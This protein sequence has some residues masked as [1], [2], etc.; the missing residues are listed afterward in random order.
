MTNGN[1]NLPNSEETEDVLK[2]EEETLYIVEKKRPKQSNILPEQ[3]ITDTDNHDI[4]MEIRKNFE[5][6]EKSV[7][8]K[9]V[10]APRAPSSSNSSASSY[11]SSS[12]LSLQQQQQE[13]A[14]TLS[15]ASSFDQKE[16]SQL[17]YEY[18]LLRVNLTQLIDDLRKSIINFNNYN[19][20]KSDGTVSLTEINDYQLHY[21]QN[22]QVLF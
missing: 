22:K 17:D 21:I 15:D 3:L 12:S 13:K 7:S 6:K 5:L 19:S 18:E 4:D 2:V 16:L 1:A 11:S 10:T 9:S 14:K 20:F 8:K